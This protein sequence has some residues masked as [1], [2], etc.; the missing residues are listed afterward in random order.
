MQSLTP[1]S[2]KRPIFGRGYNVYVVFCHQMIRHQWRK[3]ALVGLLAA[4][5]WA[6]PAS[7][8]RISST[9]FASPM[10][11]KPVDGSVLIGAYEPRGRISSSRFERTI[12]RRVALFNSFQAWGGPDSTFNSEW[13]ALVENL[14]AKNQVLMITW[15][16]WNPGNGADQPDY[17]LRKIIAG[18][19]DAYMKKWFRAVRGTRKPVFVRFA[20]EMNGDWY[21]W[22]THVN[23]PAE[24]VAAWRHVVNLSREVGADNITWVWAPNEHQTE[25]YLEKLYPGQKYVD[26]I[27]ISGYNW[28]GPGREWTGWRSAKRIF[29]PT[30][31][32]V[33]RYGKPIMIA[34]LGVNENQRADAVAPK[35]KASWLARTYAYVKN[36]DPQIKM[37]VYQNARCGNDYDW[38]VTTS[39][40][41]K[42]A[43]KRALSD[44]R[45]FA[46]FNVE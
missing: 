45:F 30:L 46:L 27:G 17:R 12:G 39:L 5:I 36:V 9:A 26:W 6:G 29:G 35:T 40:A 4:M 8:G 18:K 23:W 44:P 25:D 14:S 32:V 15:E 43:I 2:S 13:A 7:G 21:P 20:H 1:S 37:V 10:K 11:L 28:G 19:H 3:I 16:P 31:A 34:E 33:K 24:Y 42:R 41:S 38:R 22:G